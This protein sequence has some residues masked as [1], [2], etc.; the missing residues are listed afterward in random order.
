MYSEDIQ[1]G[2]GVP[3]KQGRD[4]PSHPSAA[5]QPSPTAALAAPSSLQPTNAEPVTKSNRNSIPNGDSLPN[6][7]TDAV[8]VKSV[9]YTPGLFD[10]PM[11]ADHP[12]LSGAGNMNNSAPASAQPDDLAART[13]HL[14]IEDAPSGSLPNSAPPLS[15]LG[16]GSFPPQKSVWPTHT[17][18][19]SAENSPVGPNRNTFAAFDVADRRFDK[20]PAA[21]RAEHAR[22]SPGIYYR[23]S[24]KLEQNGYGGASQGAGASAAP[25]AG[26]GA[27]L[28]AAGAGLLGSNRP[29][30]HHEGQV[31]PNAGVADRSLGQQQ[32][33]NDFSQS[34]PHF[35][36]LQQAQPQQQAQFQPQQQAQQF[37]QQQLAQFPSPPQTQQ[38]PQQQ[39]AQQFQPQQQTQ[40]F[41]AE[42]Q[43]Q[44]QQFQPVPQDQQFQAEPQAQAQQFQTEQQQQQQHHHTAAAA[45]VGAGAGLAAATGAHMLASQ[46]HSQPQTQQHTQQPSQDYFGANAVPAAQ[47]QAPQSAAMPHEQA[48]MTAPA[49]Q[50]G[51]NGS[52]RRLSGSYV[53]GYSNG[54]VPNGHAPPMHERSISEA[55]AANTAANAQYLSRPQLND[56]PSRSYVNGT[57][58]PV[59]AY[60]RPLE[61]LNRRASTRSNTKFVE[62]GPGASPTSGH[63]ASKLMAPAALAAGGLAAVGADNGAEHVHS[64]R[65]DP[66]ARPR[67]SSAQDFVRRSS[68]QAETNGPFS[69]QRPA[70]AMADARDGSQRGSHMSPSASLRGK[71]P[72]LPP[73]ADDVGYAG[74]GAGAGLALGETASLGRQHEMQYGQQLRDD[75]PVPSFPPGH[76]SQSM[77]SP[78]GQRYSSFGH[79][80]EPGIGDWAARREDGRLARSGTALSR[81]T[82][83]RSGTQRSRRS[84]AFGRG[85]AF[86][87][88]TQPEDVLG[89]DDIH[90]RTE[91][92]ERVLDP[93]TLRKL[94]GMEKKEGRHLAKLLK[95]EGKEQGRAVAAAIADLKRMARMQKDAIESE[96]KSQRMLAKATSREHGARKR[97]LKEKERYEKVEGE[98]RNAENDYE[99]R[100]DHAAGLTAQIAE[101]CVSRKGG[102]TRRTQDIDD[103]RAQKAADDREREVKLL[104]IKNPGHV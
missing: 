12:F 50:Q 70:S 43:T 37:P 78:D 76:R 63:H 38:F 31:M 46:P 24:P 98:L 71:H 42:P 103:L 20:D 67:P 1:E 32:V 11:S 83:G 2:G 100:R 15:A 21:L 19:S 79:R 80:P 48:P 34:Q 36:Q 96:R 5:S 4:Q 41:L 54:H 25:A 102:L 60:E 47:V 40:Q 10:D 90:E 17:H 95:A 56:Q 58:S 61:D 33:G 52:F 13:S 28:L 35:Q 62:P 72:R 3:N 9:Y 101:K 53:G 6:G 23:E 57:T 14:A 30:S 87:V 55:T 68:A 89:R 93:G 44:T 77:R 85:A 99:E 49:A 82:V 7:D 88:G 69:R 64:P 92:S 91:V 8:S 94:Q 18:S 45:G 29:H 73:I 39:Q 65:E 59:T 84:G 74:V 22:V 16:M 66:Y 104:A 27:G 86:S 26:A 75:G 81:T 51:N 97:F